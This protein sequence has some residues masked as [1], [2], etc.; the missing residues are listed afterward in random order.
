[1][2]RR[3]LNAAIVFESNNFQLK[4]EQSNTAAVFS[5]TVDY[6]IFIGIFGDTFLTCGL[7][8][9][10]AIT[11]VSIFVMRPN[12]LGCMQSESLL[13]N[14]AFW[15]FNATIFALLLVFQQPLLLFLIN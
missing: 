7:E 13:S 10:F 14:G 9:S 4:G 8:F 11:T 5:S 12:E 6:G 3:T 2:P 15:G 1:M